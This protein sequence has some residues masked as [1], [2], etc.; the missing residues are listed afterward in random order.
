MCNFFSG[1]IQ[2]N[3]AGVWYDCDTDSHT[4]ILRK[5]NVRD[6][7]PRA[8]FVKFEI[9]PIDG[10]I[11]NHAP[12]NWKYALDDDHRGQMG[13]PE[14][15]DAEKGEKQARKALAAVLEKVTVTGAK[16]DVEFGRKIRK[17]KNCNI[18]AIRGT[19]QEVW[20]GGTVQE[21]WGGGT[22]Q[23]VLGGGTVTTYSRN[24]KIILIQGMAIV[25]DRSGKFP[26][27]RTAEKGVTIE[28]VEEPK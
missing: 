22:V 25:I 28:F 12:E 2:P 1:I 18:G 8:S 24:A 17:A 26:V 15:Y 16:L 23:E 4:E 21:V 14:W 7:M 10:D 3:H 5:F 11:C 6:N 27:V 9:T 13:I 20:G 19:V